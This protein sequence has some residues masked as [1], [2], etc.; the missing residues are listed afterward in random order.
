MKEYSMCGA[1]GEHERELEWK[2]PRRVY[3]YEIDYYA[4]NGLSLEKTT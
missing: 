1:A 2:K 3:A 4:V